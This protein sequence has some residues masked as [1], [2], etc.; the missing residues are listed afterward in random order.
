MLSEPVRVHFAGW[1]SDTLTLQ[2][3][4]WELSAD[5]DVARD[6]MRL[7]LTHSRLGLTAL[8]KMMEWRFMQ[9]REYRVHARLEVMN[10]EF[11]G[12]SGS[13]MIRGSFPPTF[14]PID[15]EPCW[16]TEA[17]QKLEDLVH[18]ANFQQKR[19]LLPE[20]TVSDL[21]KRIIDMQQPGREAHFLKQA[22]QAPR[23]E[24]QI[25]SFCA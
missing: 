8:T 25:L 21:M 24:A 19:I 22:K 3:S 17:P 20:E 18:F 23:L 5:Q 15:A 4:G 2:R 13:L 6:T 14:R 11:F 7:A 16:S 9:E 12:R 1:E 10:V